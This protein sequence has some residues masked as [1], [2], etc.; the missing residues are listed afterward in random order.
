MLVFPRREFCDYLKGSSLFMA[1]IPRIFIDHP[2]IAGLAIEASARHTHHLLHVLRKTDGDSVWLIDPQS[3]R[4]HGEIRIQKKRHCLLIPHH[5]EQPIL[6]TRL[7]PIELWCSPLKTDMEL[8]LHIATSLNV[9]RIVPL[10]MDHTD[11][12]RHIDKWQLYIT[13]SAEQ[14]GRMDL[15]ELSPLSQL[16]AHIN[17]LAH[18]STTSLV[19]WADEQQAHLPFLPIIEHLNPSNQSPIAI[20][21]GPEGGF[22]A[23]ERS[24]LQQTT[25]IHP[26]GL[27]SN[28]LTAPIAACSLL[29]ILAAYNARFISP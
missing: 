23:K 21:I 26:I 11:Q 16:T 22:S 9:A 19:L 20:L 10:Q 12:I 6:Q 28:I 2:I 17:Q 18:Y 24:L 27:G 8:L 3:G 29:S 1:H 14:C 4:W 13:Q 25:S 7:R 15:P 5:L